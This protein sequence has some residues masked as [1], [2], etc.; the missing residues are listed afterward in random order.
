VILDVCDGWATVPLYQRVDFVFISSGRVG[1]RW[2][3]VL[4]AV[5]CCAVKLVGCDDAL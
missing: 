4:F 1:S 5:R 2:G 3:A